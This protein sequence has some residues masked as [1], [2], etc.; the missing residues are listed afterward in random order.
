MAVEIPISGSSSP[1]WRNWHSSWIG[2]SARTLTITWRSCFPFIV[3]CT[4]WMLLLHLHWIHLKVSLFQNTFSQHEI[5]KE[6]YT[7]FVSCTRKFKIP[8]FCIP[9][10]TSNRFFCKRLYLIMKKIFFPHRMLGC[11]KRHQY[12]K[13]GDLSFTLSFCWSLIS[14]WKLNLHGHVLYRPLFH[15]QRTGYY[16]GSGWFWTCLVLSRTLANTKHQGKIT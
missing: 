6:D 15:P 13:S 9:T 16:C 3:S 10:S 8:I 5:S 11:D 2:V 4:T 12:E 7:W 1:F 14:L